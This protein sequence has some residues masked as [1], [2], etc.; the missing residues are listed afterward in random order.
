MPAVGDYEY[1]NKNLYK[2]IVYDV[3]IR[4]KPIDK[5]KITG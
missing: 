1:I 3:K 4:G 2:K 5:L